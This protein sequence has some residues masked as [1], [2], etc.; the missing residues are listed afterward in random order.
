M[1]PDPPRSDRQ[2][3]LEDAFQTFT[4]PERTPLTARDDALLRRGVKFELACGLAA[5]AWGEGP[6]VL[7]AHGWNSRATHW[8]AYIEGLTAAGYRAVAIDAPGHGDSPGERC[9][10][11]EYALRLVEV[12]R[13]IGP[14]AGVVAHSFGAGAAV[15]ALDRGLAADRVALLSGPASLARVVERWGRSHGLPEADLPALLDRV[16]RAVAEPMAE[17]DLT[18]IVL[19]LRQPALIVHDRSDEE[20]PLDDGIAVAAAWPGAKI[21]VTERYG[22][23]RIMIARE[24]VRAVVEFLR[25]SST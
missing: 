19:D 22:H 1:E 6:T 16:E 3:R 7:L 13:Q 18:R 20:V 2:Q 24:V 5:T 4:T 15:L 23:R 12:A 17:L 14:L 11:L 25:D 8:A 21:L 9:H 10:V